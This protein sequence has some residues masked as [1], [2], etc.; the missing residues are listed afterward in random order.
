[1]YFTWWCDVGSVS[2]EKV[3]MKSRWMELSDD[4]FQLR[5]VI[6]IEVWI[7]VCHIQMLFVVVKSSVEVWFINFLAT[8]CF[9]NCWCYLWD[10]WDNATLCIFSGSANS[11]N[12]AA[13]T[14]IWNKNTMNLCWLNR[15]HI[16]L[17]V[18]SHGEKG[19]HCPAQVQAWAFK[20]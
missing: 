13:D 11:N 20:N 16:P 19:K 14:H 6:H 4:R 1:M 10:T 8:A 17:S 2:A 12:W 3:K 9:K 18:T 5:S 7:V 15:M